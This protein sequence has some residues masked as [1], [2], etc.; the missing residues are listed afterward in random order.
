[1]RFIAFIL[2]FFICLLPATI[3][4]CGEPSSTIIVHEGTTGYWF[5]ESTAS[6]MLQD[7]EELPPLRLKSEKL[8]LKVK[9]QE[10]LILLLREDIKI[11]EEIGNK[12][13]LAFDNQLAVTEKQE[14][15]FKKEIERLD[16]WYRS[17]VLWLGVGIIV[18]G[19]M[20]VG[21]NFGLQEVRN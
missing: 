19:A 13:K 21:L 2:T 18:G 12:W 3:V 9:G 7:L 14:E 8:E 1:M 4:L 20:A 11:T 6:R 5:P 10:E 17:P 15:E 16:A